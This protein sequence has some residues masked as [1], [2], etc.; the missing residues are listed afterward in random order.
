MNIQG[1]LPLGLTG[2]IS[3]LSKGLS[4]GLCPWDSPGKNSGLPFPSPYLLWGLP[5]FYIQPR[6]L[7]QTP[8]CY[9]EL[10]T[11]VSNWQLKLNMLLFRCSVVSDFL[12]PHGLQHTRLP[13]PLLSP[14]VC[15]NSCPL[16]QW[17]HP[18]ISPSVIPFSSCPQSFPASGSFPMNWLFAS[19]G[20]SIGA[21]AS[22][23]PM[24]IQGWLPLGLTGLISLLTKGLSIH[25]FSTQ[26]KSINFRHL[27]FFMV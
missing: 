23:F 7:P 27:G 2:L 3:L 11:W 22:V 20:Q 15:S 19:G 14:R 17:C 12:Q 1:W 21:S 5:K 16:S 25:F 6:P 9:I 4:K 10:P 18:T 8:D 24:N 13:C 26:F